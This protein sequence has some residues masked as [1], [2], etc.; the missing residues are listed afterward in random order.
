MRGSTL[1][2]ESV[3]KHVNPIA[4]GWGIFDTVVEPAPSRDSKAEPTIQ[5][6]KPSGLLSFF[7]RRDG[8]PAT[9]ASSPATTLVSTS[10]SA[11]TIASVRP[12]P[13]SGQ[14]NGAES[15][16]VPIEKTTSEDAGPLTTS[17][18]T[19][20]S[21]GEV[22]K[23][24]SSPTSGHGIH[25]D[26]TAQSAVSRFLGR[27]SRNTG[28]PDL[29]KSLSLSD[30][31]VSFLSDA[32]PDAAERKNISPSLDPFEF[33]ESLLGLPSSTPNQNSITPPLPP[34]FTP[35]Q[36]SIRTPIT[37]TPYA[38]PGAPP[39]DLAPA[40]SST[41]DGDAWDVF[42][43]APKPVPSLLSPISIAG[44]PPPHT[45]QISVPTATDPAAARRTV[46]V[47][48]LPSVNRS[49]F[50]STIPAITPPPKRVITPVPRSFDLSA[51]TR[52]TTSPSRTTDDV[53]TSP[54]SVCSQ[55]SAD[56][57]IGTRRVPPHAAGQ[58]THTPGTANSSL[59]LN[60]DSGFP[61]TIG[62]FEDFTTSSPSRTVPLPSQ[63]LA[64]ATSITTTMLPRRTV[65][66]GQ[67]A[68]PVSGSSP[69]QSSRTSSTS[70]P[71]IPATIVRPSTN[72]SGTV[73]LNFD[74]LR[75]ASPNMNSQSNAHGTPSQ[76][77][78]AAGARPPVGYF[79]ITPIPPPLVSSSH[80]STP[81]IS[82][83]SP[84]LPSAAGTAALRMQAMTPSLS[85][86]LTG[87]LA[88]P[89]ASTVPAGRSGLSAQDLS[90][91][92][93]L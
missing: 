82:P 21:S 31:G 57:S 26:F 67:P 87:G 54:I 81:P 71:T 59:L 17:T 10:V 53:T 55:L 35:S 50:V 45:Q 76:Q 85:P 75:T 47:R 60:H 90:F 44:P 83:P 5:V 9:S 62:A 65:D 88:K 49:S 11:Q 79:N 25:P 64:V 29:H 91:F 15:E 68:K 1:W 89:S 80:T 16:S 56:D 19:S 42:T 38:T 23:R 4:E 43:S 86:Q 74:F 58:P 66:A 20:T 6:K 77:G 12:T 92:E 52:D 63:L 36:S 73:S 22:A 37:A 33:N 46:P 18:N 3:K 28:G 72:G 70:S 69:R 32:I 14:H 34:P 84:I 24:R 48:M 2:E 93:N 13:E 41:M 8:V 27:F 61:D 78:V 7:S 39:A 40:F 30:T 51:D